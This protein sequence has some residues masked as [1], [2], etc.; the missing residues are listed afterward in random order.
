MS[1]THDQGEC[2]CGGVCRHSE[3][4][5]AKWPATGPGAAETSP[6]PPRGKPEEAQA[7]KPA[8][9]RL[10]S[11]CPPSLVC[12]SARQ[13]T[14]ADWPSCGPMHGAVGVPPEGHH[15]IDT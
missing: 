11:T 5:T 14:P 9:P 12:G 6:A 13:S 4:D 8:N 7:H 10:L 15:P 3:P 2:L 1:T